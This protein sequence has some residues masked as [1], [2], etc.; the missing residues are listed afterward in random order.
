M[1]T[2]Y[3]FDLQ[4]D[5]DQTQLPGF[6]A[7]EGPIGVGKTTL[8]KHLAHTFNHQTLLER[9]DKNPFLERFYQ[10]P[11]S[12]AL[13]LQLHFLFE[14]SKQL[15]NLRQ[16]DLFSPN[17]VADYLIDKDQLFAQVILDDDELRLYQKVYDMCVID[18]PKPDLVIY[19]QASVQTLMERIHQRGISSEQHLS[20]AY[21]TTLNDAYTRFFLY[22][23][24]S[25][26]LIIN[27]EDLDLVSNPDD[28]QHLVNYLLQIKSGRHY[29]NPPPKI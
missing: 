27:T 19:L 21:L 23:N 26:L 11:H 29:Y 17:R 3:G 15:E 24:R 20:E 2:S 12:A 16:N 14:R 8:A 5:L 10:E 28:Y 9:A 13:P 1:S 25:P 22:F 6:I 4:L 7:V 18:A